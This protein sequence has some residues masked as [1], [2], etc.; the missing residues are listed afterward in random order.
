M[1]PIGRAGG[2]VVFWHEDTRMEFLNLLEDCMDVTSW[3]P[4]SGQQ[5]RICFVYASTNYQ[6][7]PDL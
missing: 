4:E 1:D 3:E 6:E 7:R 2:L 5:M